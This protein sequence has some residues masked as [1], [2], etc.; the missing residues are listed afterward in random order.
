MKV[1]L[2]LIKLQ[3]PD[4]SEDEDKN[5]LDA[6]GNPLE[7]DELELGINDND[8]DVEQNLFVRSPH[9]CFVTIV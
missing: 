5:S 6:A 1:S 3:F 2:P 9:C 8:D 4:L 7:E